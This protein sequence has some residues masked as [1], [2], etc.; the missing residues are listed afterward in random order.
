M[1]YTNRAKILF[2]AVFMYSMNTRA[3]STINGQVITEDGE[4]VP[5][6][7]IGIKNTQLSTTGNVDGF[8]KF[9]NLKNGKYVFTT[10]SLGHLERKILL[11]LGWLPFLGLLRFEV[12]RCS[13]FKKIFV[14]FAYFGYK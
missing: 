12:G 11:K 9:K 7:V 14:Y 2:A 8:F 1:I 5:F 13:W 10:K 3:Q 4:S 6:A